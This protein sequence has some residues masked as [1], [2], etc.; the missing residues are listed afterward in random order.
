MMKSITL[1]LLCMGVLYAQL[2]WPHPPQNQEH[3]IGNAWGNYQ[4]YGSGPYLH[5]GQDIL[6]T[7]LCPVTAIK[8]GY[9]KAIWQSGQLY[10]GIS[11]ADS[12]G[13]A[14]C[15]GYMYYH[16]DPTTIQVSVG[17]TVYP[18]DTI[19][20]IVTWPVYNFHHNHFSKNRNSGT[21]WSSYGAFIRNPLTEFT[22][23]YDSTPPVFTDALSGQEF[24]ICTNNTSI[25]L[26]PDSIYGDVDFICRVKDR[27]NDPSWWVIV[28]KIMYSIYDTSGTYVVPPTIG[29]QF[30]D[31]LE[32][33]V[34]GQERT[35]FKDDATCNTTC[36]YTNASR[37]YYYIFTNTN[38]DSSIMATDSLQS[39]QT[40]TVQNGP[41]W[42]KVV[43]SDEYGN[44]VAE[45]MLVHVRNPVGIEEQEE[46]DAGQIAG[47]IR[48]VPNPSRST[49]HFHVVSGTSTPAELYI[50]DVTGQMIRRLPVD[51]ASNGQ[52]VHIPWDRQDNSGNNV[53]AGVYYV[54][55]NGSTSEDRVKFVL[56][57]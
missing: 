6:T 39:W 38:G 15:Y 37:R 21:V 57:H 34:A 35:V 10:T 53:P 54:G 47:P 7:P 25:Y 48:V 26:D 9:V 43:A 29:F 55:G 3:P 49:I 33:Y 31:S 19:A 4:D 23:D 36:D 13:A 5:N 28:Y 56:L 11:V 42:V 1:I 24:A 20:Q 2:P 41:Y 18:G 45:S 40:T 27:I 17:D 14:Q 44:S 8:M 16:V 30:S 52:A 50:Y 12:A 51:V 46:H 32:S 22:P